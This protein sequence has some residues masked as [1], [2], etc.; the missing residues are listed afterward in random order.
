MWRKASIPLQFLIQRSP[1]H[2]PELAEQDRAALVGYFADDIDIVEA[3]TGW[4]LD[5]WR[6]YRE[7]GTYSV[8]KSWAPSRRLVS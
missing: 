3:E 4:D 1:Q 8:R 5:L 7:G 6:S 2:R